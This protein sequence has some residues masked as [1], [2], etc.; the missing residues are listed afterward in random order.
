MKES[1]LIQLP[2]EI[3]CHIFD[4]I[5]F[6]ELCT[7]SLVSQA[8]YAYF[9]ES[10][11]KK[12]GKILDKFERRCGGLKKCSKFLFLGDLSVKNEKTKDREDT[13][14][15]TCQRKKRAPGKGKFYF[16]VQPESRQER[17]TRFI[18]FIREKVCAPDVYESA[19][20]LAKYKEN[21]NRFLVL[22]FGIRWAQKHSVEF[23]SLCEWSGR[24]AQFKSVLSS[25]RR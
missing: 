2:P 24:N 17:F 19:P 20:L 9:C 22:T 10:R 18:K 1:I 4:H 12:C 6:A 23:L 15:K 21:V 11:N 16:P 8:F 7:V 13:V 14:C 5:D 3:W 25:R